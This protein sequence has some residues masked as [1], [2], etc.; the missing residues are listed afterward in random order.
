MPDHAAHDYITRSINPRT[1][2]SCR[3]SPIKLGAWTRDVLVLRAIE[4]A[5]IEL[6]EKKLRVARHAQ[7]T[8]EDRR[9]DRSGEIVGR[10]WTESIP[11]RP[12]SLSLKV[13][14]RF[15]RLGNLALSDDRSPGSFWVEHFHP[16]K[17]IKS[18]SA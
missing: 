6:N 11:K 16:S 1:G 15:L 13:S 9:I 10:S 18:L 7:S 17:L 12:E 4:A 5:E 8:I 3:L 14:K 2:K